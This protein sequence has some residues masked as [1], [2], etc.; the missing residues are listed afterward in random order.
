MF[1]IDKTLK[2][3]T[4]EIGN[5]KP[6][7]IIAEAGVNHNGSFD[8]AIKLIEEA[9]KTG[10]NCVK[11]QTF[12][13]EN[14]I[15]KEAPKAQYQMK[16]TDPKESQ[17][18]MLEK[19]ELTKD[20][21]VKLISHCE[22]IGMQFLSTPYNKEDAD[23]LMELGVSA[24][25]IASGQLVEIPF[26][27]HVSRLGKPIII[28]SG[29]ANL[30]EVYEGVQAIREEGND[31]I[32]LLQCTTNY[33]SSNQDANIKAMKIMGEANGV[34][35]GYSDHVPN[36][37]AAYAATALGASVIEKHFTLDNDLPGPDHSSSLN[38]ETFAELVNGI[39]LVEQSLGNKV[40]SPTEEEKKNI[41]GMRRSIVLLEPLSKGEI[42]QENNTG[43]K[44]PATGIAP[45]ELPN[46][47][48]KKARIDIPADTPLQPEMIDY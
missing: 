38:P 44:R 16:V 41:Q 27:R 45:K 15:T 35:Y 42:I 24:F 18:E 21:Y 37:F 14:I 30:A 17:Y 4:S 36:N 2:I 10:A 40:K 8:L 7:Y 9:K 48:G 29:M 25:K 34:L 5:E 19:L 39:R 28:S 31:Q 20:E 23:F 3:N 33:P 22:E 47:V 11:F 43:F 46:L 1:A 12:K 13:A 6:V 26:L 32:I